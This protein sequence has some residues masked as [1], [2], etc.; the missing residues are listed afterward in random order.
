KLMTLRWIF[1]RKKLSK[2]EIYEEKTQQGIQGKGGDR[3]ATRGEKGSGD[4]PSVISGL[5]LGKPP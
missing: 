4:S 1:H 3:G 5:S 2:E